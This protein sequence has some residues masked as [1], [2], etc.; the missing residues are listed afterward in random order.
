M[1]IPPKRA[2]TSGGTSTL[3]DN[4]A[5]I[6]VTFFTKD[7]ASPNTGLQPRI[8]FDLDLPDGR[9]LHKQATFS[10]DQFTAATDRCD[11]KIANNSFS[12]DLHDYTITAAIED[13]SFTAHL[14]GQTEPWRSAAGS[15]YYGADEEKYFSW[16]PSVP[17]GHVDLTYKVGN[18]EGS[19][20]TRQRIPRSQLGEML[21]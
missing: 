5:K 2:S 16:L 17:Y 1:P 20:Y 11:V 13:I 7:A 18:E 12:G 10:A 19:D 4:G 8:E 14:S 3:I 9:S 15:I 6:V 21:R